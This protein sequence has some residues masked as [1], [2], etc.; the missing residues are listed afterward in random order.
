MRSL[1]VALIRGYR[2]LLS[3]WVGMHCRFLPTCSAYGIEALQRH[4]AI[5]GVWLTLRRVARCHPWCR[6]GLDP[7]PEHPWKTHG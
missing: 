3:P 1:F 4:G 7:V 6:G 5:A 2:Y